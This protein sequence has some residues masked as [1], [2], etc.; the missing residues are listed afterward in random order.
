VLTDEENGRSQDNKD[1]Q[2]RLAPQ[3]DNSSQ[4]NPHEQ[5]LVR[6]AIVFFFSCYFSSLCPVLI[7]GIEFYAKWGAKNY[8]TE[9]TPLH[10]FFI[11]ESVIL[12]TLWPLPCTDA[13]EHSSMEKF[14]ILLLSRTCPREIHSNKTSVLLETLSPSNNWQRNN[15]RITL[16]QSN[17]NLL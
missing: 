16:N 1:R 9:V 13:R 11:T 12:S 17:I 8:I 10:C 6:W 7:P 3:D 4:Q 5:L 14:N 15:T 2:P